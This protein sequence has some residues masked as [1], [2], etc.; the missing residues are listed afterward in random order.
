MAELNSIVQKVIQDLLDFIYVCCYIHGI[1]RQY[2]LDTNGFLATG[3]F[4]GGSSVTDDL[5]DEIRELALED[6]IDDVSYIDVRL[7]R[8][9]SYDDI[10]RA[11]QEAEDEAEMKNKDKFDRLCKIVK[12]CVMNR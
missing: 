6:G 10:I 8:D 12:D 5:I 3:T 2:Q 9:A 1:S 11:T 4:K 7:P